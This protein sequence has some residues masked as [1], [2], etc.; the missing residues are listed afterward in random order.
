VSR[1][2]DGLIGVRGGTGTERP[3]TLKVLVGIDE[4]FQAEAEVSFAGP[5]ALDRARLSR[6]VLQKRLQRVEGVDARSVRYDLIGLDAIHGNMSERSERVPYEVRL[7]VAA[8]V[9]TEILAQRITHEVEW[10]YFGPAGAG[11]MRGRIVPA[12][13]M[14]STTLARRE[15]ITTV[16][17]G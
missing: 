3:S 7:R 12:L 4:G 13:S 10:Q 5:G 16:T 6:D 15:V 14:Y 17:M 2:A 1:L 9:P 11:G 8:R